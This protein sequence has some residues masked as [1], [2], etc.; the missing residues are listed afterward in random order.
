MTKH[1]PRP[2]VL[3]PRDKQQLH[4]SPPPPHVYRLH[5]Y[6]A[7]IGFAALFLYTLPAPQNSGNDDRPRM[8]S[9][10]A[11]ARVRGSEA[12]S[13]NRADLGPP[14][15]APT[16]EARL[17]AS[18][19]RDP[20]PQVRHVG[21]WSS[22]FEQQMGLLSLLSYAFDAFGLQLRPFA[23]PLPLSYCGPTSN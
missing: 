19:P 8:K 23:A 18:A 22:C 13:P 17:R 2:R 15:D 4:V 6:P 5:L 16:L 20:S 1:L 12:A 14:P 3:F 9:A 21:I 11:S 10:R 7:P